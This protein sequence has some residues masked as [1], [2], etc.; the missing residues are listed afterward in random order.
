MRPTKWS[1]NTMNR[2]RF[3]G[4]SYLE[5]QHSLN[6]HSTFQHI[7]GNSWSLPITFY[8]QS[9]FSSWQRA[10]WFTRISQEKLLPFKKQVNYLTDSILIGDSANGFAH[11]T[12]TDILNEEEK[13]S[14]NRFHTPLPIC[15]SCCGCLLEIF[16]YVGCKD[17]NIHITSHA[18]NGCTFQIECD[19]RMVCVKQLSQYT[20]T[21]KKPKSALKAVADSEGAEGDVPPPKICQKREKCSNFAVFIYKMV[22]NAKFS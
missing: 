10:I 2:E 8:R 1:R 16:V 3:C 18:D 7:R 4:M 9:F 13:E 21:T 20:F 6:G 17:G 15:S 19:T 14:P 12:C 22:K 5:S 11:K